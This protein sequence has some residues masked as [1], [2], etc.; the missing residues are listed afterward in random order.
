MALTLLWGPCC[1]YAG[2]AALEL[3]PKCHSEVDEA[4]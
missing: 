1:A 3:G 2:K 4:I